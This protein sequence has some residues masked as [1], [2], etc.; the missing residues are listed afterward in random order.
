[1]KIIKII[2]YT[3]LISL[4]IVKPSISDDFNNWLISFKKYAIKEGVSKRTLEKTMSNVKFLPK[5]IKY[6]R[7]QPEFYED[8]K[9]YVSKRT[10][11]KKLKIG[12]KI[13]QNNID[14]INLISNNFKV[15]KSLL[16]L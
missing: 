7:Y 15:D 13:Y 2:F 5:V 10:S 3:I 1:M 12:N 9:T 4:T 14:K 8:T 6:D 11:I 16:L